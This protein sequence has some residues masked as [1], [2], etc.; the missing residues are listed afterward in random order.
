MG[1]FTE[2]MRVIE[3]ERKQSEERWRKF[4]MQEPTQEFMRSLPMRN[5][6]PKEYAMWLCGYITNGGRITHNYEY[7]IPDSFMVALQEFELPRACGA[8]SR[9]V[10]CPSGITIR[11]NGHCNVYMMD[12]FKYDGHGWV[13][14]YNDVA[15]ILDGM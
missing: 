15:K 12:E 8:L 14:L 9:N 6:K 1:F 4:Y 10:I 5:A 7:D 2:H 3:R 11:A 13:P